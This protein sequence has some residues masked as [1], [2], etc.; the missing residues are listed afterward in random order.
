MRQTTEPHDVLE[1]LLFASD[2]PVEAALIQD[3]LDLPTADAARALVAD[4]Q[5]RFADQRR[6]LQIIEVGG[7]FRL[8][9]RPEVAPPSEGPGRVDDLTR[10]AP[11]TA[12]QETDPQSA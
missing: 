11:G 7:G 10:A 12:H 4:L 5:H 1:A 6:V 9:T 2:A 3:V 8:V